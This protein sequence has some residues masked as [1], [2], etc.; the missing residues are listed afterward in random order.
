MFWGILVDTPFL[1]HFISFIY[2]CLSSIPKRGQE[3]E[4]LFRNGFCTYVII[5]APLWVSGRI[6][7]AS[8][9]SPPPKSGFVW[10]RNLNLSRASLA[11][12]QWHMIRRERSYTFN[13]R[14]NCNKMS[15]PD[16]QQKIMKIVYTYLTSSLKKTS[17]WLYK[18]CTIRSSSLLTCLSAKIEYL[19]FKRILSKT[20]SHQVI[21]ENGENGRI[22]TPHRNKVQPSTKILLKWKRL[23][24]LNGRTMG[25]CN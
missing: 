22:S 21:I 17:L 5:S 23:K 15:C 19:W 1:H 6:L 25:Y 14:F 7:I 11:L 20:I 2:C 12:L 9:V 10:L 3:L 18:L 13:A 16:N 24:E 4:D 8:S